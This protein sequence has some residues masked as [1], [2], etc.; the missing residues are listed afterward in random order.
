MGLQTETFTASTGSELAPAF[1]ALARERPDA[2]FVNGDSFFN[3]RRLQIGMLAARHVIPTAFASRDYPHSGG[4]MSY[5]TNVGDAFRQV[6]VYAGR[7][8]KGA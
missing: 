5:G 8:L 2:L 7:I 4:L 6:G 3:T 1:A